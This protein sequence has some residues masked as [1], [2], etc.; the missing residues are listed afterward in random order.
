MI[1]PRLRGRT[2]LQAILKHR[3]R[4]GYSWKIQERTA[5]RRFLKTTERM[6][7]RKLDLENG[8]VKNKK[9]TMTGK[10]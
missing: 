5:S 9:K 4:P 8:I 10:T 2:P 7:S 3:N 1:S 6:P